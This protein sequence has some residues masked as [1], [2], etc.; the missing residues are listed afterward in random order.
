M[1][2]AVKLVYR[3]LMHQVFFSLLKLLSIRKSPLNF[4]GDFSFKTGKG[5]SI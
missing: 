2:H 4:K 1:V 5:N 3:I